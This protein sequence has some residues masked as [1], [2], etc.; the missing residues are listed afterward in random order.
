MQRL[1]NAYIPAP[2]SAMTGGMLPVAHSSA[3]SAA[4]GVLI[5]WNATRVQEI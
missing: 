5:F 1:M 2:L 4:S 3:T